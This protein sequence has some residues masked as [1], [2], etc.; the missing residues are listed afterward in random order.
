MWMQ[1][2]NPFGNEYVSALVAF[3]PIL[4]FLVGLTAFKMKGILAAG[5][6]LV[7]S[8]AVA[9][10]VFQMPAL[11][12]LSA[13]VLGFGNGLWPIGYIVLMA[14]WLY[15]LAVKSGKFDVIRGS[16]AS[17]SQD[18]RLQLLLIGFSFN[19]FLEGAAGFGVPIAIS[20]ALLTQIGFKPLKAAGLCLIANA[21]SGAFGAIGIPVITG[22]QLGGISS[23]ELSRTLA[24]LLPPVSFVIPFL[25]VFIL[26]GFKG[27]KETLPALLVLS[28]TYT[29]IQTATMIFIGP[30]LANIGAALIS[31][32]VLA[33]FLRKWQPKHIY[34]EQGAEVQEQDQRYTIG[35]VAKAWSPFY[36]LTLVIALWSAPFFKQ[37][38][39]ADGPLTGWIAYVKMPFLHQE[40]VTIAPIAVTNTPIDAILKLDFVSATGTAILAAVILTSL[41]SRNINW[42]CAGRGLQEAAKELWIPVLTI[43]FIMAFANLS[44]YAGLSAAIGLA[45][46]KTG[47]LFPL[48]S[49]ILGWIGVFIT[50]SVVSNN[51]LFGTLQVVTGSQIGTSSALLLSA[52][53]AGGVMAKLISPQSIAIATAAV[54]ETG[55]ESALFNMTIKYSLLLAGFVC[56]LTFILSLFL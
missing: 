17:I 16:I 44:N 5:L 51:A 37:L 54:K 2:Y 38:F 45:L 1:A 25:L 34:R 22:A 31:M 49:P 32:G 26:N 20:A 18:H 9:V 28:G 27:I 13:I 23:L 24:F 39:A 19:A 21:A 50:G 11:K 7:I 14:V 33:L 56:I 10:F 42:N 8:F 36:I 55:N 46:A 47:S 41:F 40:V 30:E 35:Q 43:C 15:K 29:I 48:F 6:T 3:L 4:F 12:A 52:N 53:T